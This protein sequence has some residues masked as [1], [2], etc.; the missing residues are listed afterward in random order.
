VAVLT[1]SRRFP[2]GSS[3]DQLAR[4]VRRGDA[5]TVLAVLDAGDERLR[6]DPHPADDPDA[7]ANVMALAEPSALDLVASADAGDA[8]QALASLDR[9]R[10]LCAH[11]EGPFGVSWWNHHTEARLRTRGVDVTG[12]YP[13][14][15][16]MI[17]TNDYANALFNGD[18]G[19]VVRHHDRRVVAFPDAAGFRQLGLSRLQDVETVHA[20]TIHKSQGSEFDHVAVILP[21]ADSPLATRELLY[22]AITRARQRVTV[23]GDEAAVRAAVSRRVVRAGGLRSALWPD[24]SATLGVR[25]W[26]SS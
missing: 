17:T 25:G 24:P 9:F 19:V 22:T 1:E 12:W 13:G 18:L 6:W 7:R 8:E 20:T 14:R 26:V 11:R 3:I 23:V 10:I 21:P 16:V 15:P 2:T 5:D 4:A